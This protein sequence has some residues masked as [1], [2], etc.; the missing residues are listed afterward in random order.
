MKKQ[1]E[2]TECETFH[3]TPLDAFMMS[4]IINSSYSDIYIFT[5]LIPLVID[6]LS[7]RHTAV[8]SVNFALGFT[9]KTEIT[10]SSQPLIS[11][12]N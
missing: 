4:T 2:V 10:F 12:L 1:P 9:I 8:Y 3:G 6:L 11:R 5:F 7:Y